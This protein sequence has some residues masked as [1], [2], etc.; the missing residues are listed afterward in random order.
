MLIWGEIR[1]AKWDNDIAKQ[2]KRTRDD[3]WARH[4]TRDEQ[5]TD[6]KH[7]LESSKILWLFGKLWR[8]SWERNVEWMDLK[9]IRAVDRAHQAVRRAA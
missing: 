8:H 1:I 9:A 3:S 4:H 6:P 2:T 7:P 5:T